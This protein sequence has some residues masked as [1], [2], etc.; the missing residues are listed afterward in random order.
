MKEAKSA[1]L[2]H[3][4]N[5]EQIHHENS[6]LGSSKFAKLFD[7]EASW[8]KDQL[9]DVLHWIRQVVGL[10]CG[11]VWGSIPLVGVIWLLLLMKKTMGVMQLCSRMVYLLL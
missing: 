7:S 2:N 4:D 11:L 3:Q 9:G 1:K 6:H 8:D 10:L 5:N